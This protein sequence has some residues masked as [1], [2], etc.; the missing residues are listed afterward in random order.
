MLAFF[1]PKKVNISVYKQTANKTQKVNRQKWA[2]SL[3]KHSAT[4]GGGIGK[5]QIKLILQN[6]KQ[7]LKKD[8]KTRGINSIIM[9]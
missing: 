9:A 4:N 7:Q 6:T 1:S 3:E 8:K 2:L 5:I